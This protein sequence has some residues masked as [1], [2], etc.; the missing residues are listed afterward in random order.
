VP[1]TVAV[2][3]VLTGHHLLRL[4]GQSVKFTLQTG[5]LTELLITRVRLEVQLSVLLSHSL[6]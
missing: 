1:L 6:L 4:G 5:Q 3:S 2:E